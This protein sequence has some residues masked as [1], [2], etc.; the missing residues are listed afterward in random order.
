MKLYVKDLTYVSCY[1]NYLHYI[2][3]AYVGNVDL[4]IHH[5]NWMEF[6]KK[7]VCNLFTQN[8]GIIW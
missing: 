4:Q 6:V 7:R 2:L 1:I 3:K 5:E 8:L